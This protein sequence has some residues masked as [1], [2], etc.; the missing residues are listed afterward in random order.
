[1]VWGLLLS[2]QTLLIIFFQMIR[3]PLLTCGRVF[4]CVLFLSL[5]ERRKLSP[6]W[7]AGVGVFSCCGDMLVRRGS[8][9]RGQWVCREGKETEAAILPREE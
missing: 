8:K 3:L 6:A 1:M 4:S 7:Q 5:N 2:D 9:V